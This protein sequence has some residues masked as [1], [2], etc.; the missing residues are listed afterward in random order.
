[1]PPIHIPLRREAANLSRMRSPIT[2]RSN[3]ERQSQHPVDEAACDALCFGQFP[4]RSVPAIF[5]HSLPAMRPRQRAH[6]RLV[7]PRFRWRPGVAAVGSDDHLASAAAPPGY[8]RADGN[9]RAIELPVLAGTFRPVFTP[10]S[11]PVTEFPRPAPA[12]PRP[13]AARACHRRQGRL[14]NQQPHDPRLLGRK[15]CGRGWSTSVPFGCSP[16]SLTN[17]VAAASLP[18]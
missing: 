14:L 3:Q 1:M 15:Q 16:L 10:P 4:S 17:L 11:P 18:P 12:A 8:R 6:Q 7:R 5:Q 2:S 13:A 9:R